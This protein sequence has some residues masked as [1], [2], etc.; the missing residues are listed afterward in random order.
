M[1]QSEV[2]IV[3]LAPELKEKLDA[4]S[5]NTK[6]SI[7]CLAAEAITLYVEAQSWQINKIEQAMKLANSLQS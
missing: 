3:E 5:R 1:P 2:L 6:R 7:S 4:L